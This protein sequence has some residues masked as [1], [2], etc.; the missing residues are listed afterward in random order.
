MKSV[1]H[2]QPSRKEVCHLQPSRKEVCHLHRKEVFCHL[3]PSRKEV[4]HLQPSR[5]DVCH[6]QPS[7]KYVTGHTHTHTHSVCLFSHCGLAKQ[8]GTLAV[9]RVSSLSTPKVL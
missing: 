9:P 1:C 7:R 4:C 2:L 3:Q 8:Q 6:L 5:K